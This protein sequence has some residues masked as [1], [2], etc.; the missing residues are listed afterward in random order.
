MKTISDL[1]RLER[2]L[3]DAVASDG[4][5]EP[6]Q[7]CDAAVKLTNALPRSAGGGCKD[8]EFF[9]TEKL[10][11]YL[12]D[13]RDVSGKAVKQ[14]KPNG[15]RRKGRKGDDA[16]ARRI[17][18]SILAERSAELNATSSEECCADLVGALVGDSLFEAKPW[19]GSSLDSARHMDKVQQTLLNSVR[20]RLPR[21]IAE[22][23]RSKANKDVTVVCQSSSSPPEG[24][25][26]QLAQ[27]LE[28][29]VATTMRLDAEDANCFV[30]VAKIEAK[31]EAYAAIARQL[32][33][34]N[35]RLRR[36]AAADK[37]HVSHL[38]NVAS[39]LSAVHDSLAAR[40]EQ[41]SSLVAATTSAALDTTII[42]EGTE[43]HSADLTA[44]HLKIAFDEL[45]TERLRTAVVRTE[46]VG[47]LEE[48]QEKI[49]E[50]A[51]AL[52]AELN[53]ACQGS[54]K[55]WCMNQASLVKPDKVCAMTRELFREFHEDPERFLRRV[56]S[57]QKGACRDA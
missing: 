33:A 34:Q 32:L 35:G 13:E 23:V 28:K 39:G 27:S 37:L 15:L 46:A 25:Y 17:I 41:C 20:K 11:S 12:S 5:K 9:Q 22:K 14:N 18:R 8:G 26:D 53:E 48:E 4:L 3:R 2:E 51:E 38:E 40:L 30:D 50:L 31:F 24:E 56:H 6:N 47:K 52:S 44:T 7:A 29:R 49:Q 43:A 21:L 54:V 10:L 36:I 16:E 1:E 42:P 57:A 19:V 55:T 45:C